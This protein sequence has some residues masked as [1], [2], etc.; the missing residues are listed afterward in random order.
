MPVTLYGPGHLVKARYTPLQAMV[1]GV[2][3]QDSPHHDLLAA[4]GRY[5]A[6][7][8]STR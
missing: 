2:D 7:A 5:A 8:S 4:K 1:Q 6:L 3:E